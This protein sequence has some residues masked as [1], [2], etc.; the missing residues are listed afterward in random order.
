MLGAL[1][2]T[3]IAGYS[4]LNMEGW[5]VAFRTVAVAAFVI[6]FVVLYYVK[7]PRNPSKSQTIEYAPL[8]AHGLRDSREGSLMREVKEESWREVIADFWTVCPSH[9]CCLVDTAMF[10][11]VAIGTH[12]SASLRNHVP[13]ILKDEQHFCLPFEA[14]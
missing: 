6:G 1:Y 2:A 4:P 11:N 5:R 7:D 3:N 13:F 8:S 10:W 9:F 12:K 14:M